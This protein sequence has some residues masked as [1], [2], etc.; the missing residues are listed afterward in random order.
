MSTK[1]LVHEFLSSC[2]Q[3]LS[4]Y[5]S[6]ELGLSAD[7]ALRFLDVLREAGFRPLGVD[8]WRKRGTALSVEGLDAWYP[9][10]KEDIW[11][12]VEQF[13]QS[14]TLGEGEMFTIQF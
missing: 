13:L 1:H 14:T 5:G 12:S 7:D 3:S 9:D 4:E 6:G 10:A 2:G 11:A 8:V